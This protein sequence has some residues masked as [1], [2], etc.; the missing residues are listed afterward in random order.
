MGS[1]KENQIKLE[2][3][4]TMGKPLNEGGS[5]NSVKGNM[6]VDQKKAYLDKS[7]KELMKTGKLLNMKTTLFG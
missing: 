3:V 1:I 7:K 4:E 6:T 5:L 2:R